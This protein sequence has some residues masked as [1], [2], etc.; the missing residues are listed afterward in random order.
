MGDMD[1]CTTSSGVFIGSSTGSRHDRILYFSYRIPMGRSTFAYE[2]RAIVGL[3]H[4]YTENE[5][6]SLSK[7]L[8]RQ[9]DG[10]VIPRE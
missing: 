8:G 2:D 1:T 3:E 10:R 9:V 5:F 4:G 7:C 6:L